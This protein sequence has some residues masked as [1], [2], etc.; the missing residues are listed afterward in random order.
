MLQLQLKKRSHMK[1]DCWVKGGSKE[2]QGLRKKHQDG[3]LSA[4]QQDIEAWAAIKEISGS[5]DSSYM[6]K[7]RA[8]SELYDSGASCH[9][10]P[11]RHQFISYRSTDPR[12]IMVVD[13]C[14][15][16]ATGV[17]DLRIQVPNGDTFTPV[18]LC[19]ALHAPE[20][21]LTVVSISCITKAGLVVS[22]E[23]N[24]CNITNAEG[25]VVGRIPS[26]SNGLY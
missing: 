2:G 17:G 6:C 26:N 15:F 23:G 7:P 16:F 3:A 11:F 20:M 1:A 13:K 8:E 18:I 14:L 4:E 21:A 25:K 19:N 5:E 12:P 24:A 10:S 9:M 22:F